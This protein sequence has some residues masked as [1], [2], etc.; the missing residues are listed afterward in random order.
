MLMN[1]GLGLA[2]LVRARPIVLVGDEV[3]QYT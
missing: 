1:V 3:P 2:P